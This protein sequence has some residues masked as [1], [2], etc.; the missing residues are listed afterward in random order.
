MTLHSRIRAVWRREQS[1]CLAEGALAF[2]RWGLVMFL[3][4]A[5]IDWQASKRIV[6]IPGPGRLAILLVVLGV[7][8]RK[9][10]RAGWQFIRPFNATRT[11]LQIEAHHGGMESLLVAALQLKSQPQCHGTSSALCELTIRK[12]E[13]AAGGIQPQ[14]AVQYQSLRRPALMALGV[15]LLIGVIA[16]TNGPLLMAGLGR[17]FA[18]WLTVSYPTRT[19]I[20]LVSGDTVV[21]E[22][23]PVRIAARVSGAVPRK[24]R[25]HLRTGSGRPRVRQLPIANGQCAYVI[26]TAYRGFQ[27]RLTAG[28]ARSPWHEVEV[29]NAP[30]IERAEVTLAFPAYTERAVETV[31]ALTLTVPETTRIRWKLSIDRPVRKATLN[32]AGEEPIA[33]DISKDGRTVS[34]EQVAAGSRAYAFAWVE[35]DHGFQFTSPNNYLQ[36]APDRPPRVELTSPDR[37]IAATLGRKVDLAFRGQD[38]HGI[39]ES[40]IA[41]RVDKTEE[42]RVGFT[43]A[44][45]VDGTVQAIDWDY[46]TFLTNLVVGQTIS[47][48]VEIADRYPGEDG[49]HRARSE[50]R[51]IQFMTREDYLA[52]I[53]KQ[54]NRLLAQLRGIYREERSVNELVMRLD[55]SDAVFIQTCQLEAVR[56]DLMRERVNTLADQMLGI[57]EDLAANGITDDPVIETLVRMRADLLAISSDNLGKAADAL[58]ALA[59]TSGKARD[60][61]RLAHA[62]HRVNSSARE[63]GLLVLQLGFIDAA[64][65]MARELHSAA[66]TQ[67]ALRLQTMM[68][69]GTPGELAD[70]QKRLAEW[71]TRLFAASPRNRES[72]VEEALVEFTLSRLVKKMTQGGIAERL[73]QAAV[74]IADGKTAEAATLQAEVIKSLLN[75]EF[76]LR[77]GSERETLAEARDLF[78]SQAVR[79]RALREETQSLDSDAFKRRQVELSQAQAELHGN[80]QGLLMPAVP[81][82]PARLFDEVIPP[83]PP[84]AEL[85]TSADITTT[86]AVASIGNGDRK[87]AADYQSQAESAFNEL[88]GIV[89]ERIAAMTR[90]VRIGRLVYGFADIDE[91]IG[92]LIERQLSLLEKTEDAAAD[93]TK[94]DYLADHEQDLADAVKEL[95]TEIADRIGTSPAPSENSLALPARIEE[96]LRAMTNAVPLLAGEKPGEAA[97]LQDTAVAALSGAQALL[98]EHKANLSAYTA[99][100]GGTDA[101]VSPSPYVSEIEEEQCDMVT[102]TR[103]A[104]PENLP[105][106]SIPQKNLVHAVNAVLTALNPVAHLVESGTIMLFAKD[107]MDS[108]GI[109]LADKDPEEALDAQTYVVE[110]LQ[111]LRVKLDAIIPPFLYIQELVEALHE[112]IPEG[113]LIREAQRALREQSMAGVDSA[114]IAAG[115][116]ALLARTEA[117]RGLINRV[118]GLDCME[119]AARH[120]G[121]ARTQLEAGDQAATANEMKQAEESLRTG[122]D[123][124]L[125]LMSHFGLVYSAP[126]PTKEISPE[127]LLLRDVLQ[128][129]AQQKRF[130]RE[131]H[132]A[133]ADQVKG[134]EPRLAAF[135][136]ACEP[137]IEI[138]SQHKRPVEAVKTKSKGRQPAPE[139][140]PAP[141]A[142]PADFQR[143]LVV[144]RDRLSQAAASA[145]SSAMDKSMERQ[146]EAAD[147]LRHF[148]VEYTMTF[149]VPPPPPPPQDPAPTDDFNESEDMMSLF[150]PGAV[151]GTRP[152]D[153]RLEWEVLGKRDRAALNENFARELPL[154]YRAIL[155][156]YYER[157]AK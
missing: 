37:D 131:C 134:F 106:L 146:R 23:R 80:L 156:D 128:M 87:A 151:T 126:Q 148:V 99:I 90:K 121:E 44:K 101:A 73:E 28:D 92:R 33:L 3:G 139:T 130:F 115:Q 155:K 57:T 97:V 32:P 75:A 95:G 153:G 26:E 111:D 107:D 76:R 143:H 105:A 16:A 69:R 68:T 47:F 67:A 118:T 10:W 30:H 85:L 70:S 15:V 83:A 58:R 125:K 122:T 123:E 102:A 109:A 48:A 29:I 31:E 84:V 46:R 55:P 27:Y 66:Q 45:P 150:M 117:Y 41:Y 96:A 140:E 78:V 82:R 5:F 72:T 77:V 65:V 52:Q 61:A 142:P 110:T 62:V 94:S 124:L 8:L 60:G 18:P 74:F 108:A 38:D 4:L 116:G 49:P 137:F 2:L 145:R 127:V 103:A 135:V 54:K 53:E 50:S 113:I 136:S 79:Q 141:P 11:A 1:W 104:K 64:D 98:A 132:A 22:G 19:Q 42:Q 13:A 56:Q 129:A 59:G 119:A 71:L 25:I 6:D 147:S 133:K 93:E 51:R 35:R 39:A 81:E 89:Q 20:E 88:A 152:P 114:A 112:L 154:E 36:V 86:R 63:L 157:L 9:A 138:A 14:E 91:R 144:A 17:I 40:V 24:A 12:A 120:S 149:V 7:S 34:V 21:Q 100:L 43:P